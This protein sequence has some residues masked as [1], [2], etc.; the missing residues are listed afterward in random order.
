MNAFPWPY[1]EPKVSWDGILTFF[2]G[3]LALWAIWRQT[4][5]ADDG[6]RKQLEG[7]KRAREEEKERRKKSVATGLLFEVDS[8]YQSHL[9]DFLG[10]KADV[11]LSELPFIR[12]VALNPFPVYEANAS[13]IGEFPSD[14]VADIVKFYGVAEDYLCDLRDYREAREAMRGNTASSLASAWTIYQRLREAAPGI[15][16][17]VHVICEKLCVLT[18]TPFV[19]PPIAIV[20]EGLST[21]NIAQ[22]LARKVEA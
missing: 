8:F 7:E 14:L 17:C 22:A 9:Q 19:W 15:R 6:L 21:E 13:S 16:N 20:R 12:S 3:L 5:H 10:P 11:K 4:S 1:L 18:G 2:G